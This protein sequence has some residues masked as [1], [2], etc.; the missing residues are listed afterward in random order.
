M[1]WYKR[2]SGFEIGNK[3]TTICKKSAVHLPVVEAADEPYIISKTWLWV[4]L[5]ELTELV[6]GKL[7]P[8][9]ELLSEV[10]QVFGANGI[11]ERFSRYIYGDEMLIISYRVAYSGTPNIFPPNM[12]PDEQLA[13]L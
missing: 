1:L 7:L 9:I 5:N 6:Y 8:T 4:P 3:N 2:K 12:L 13:C 11:I 10:F